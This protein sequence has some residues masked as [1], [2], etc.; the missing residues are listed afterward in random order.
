M[1]GVKTPFS[2]H[3]LTLRPGVVQAAAPGKVSVRVRTDLSRCRVNG[4]DRGSSLPRPATEK[5]GAVSAAPGHA[6]FYCWN[7]RPSTTGGR[8]DN[9]GAGRAP[10]PT[11]P[12]T[13]AGPFSNIPWCAAPSS[14]R[15]IRGDR[16]DDERATNRPGASRSRIVVSGTPRKCGAGAPSLLLRSQRPA[17][18]RPLVTGKDVGGMFD[19]PFWRRLDR[20]VDSIAWPWLMIAVIVMLI[21]QALR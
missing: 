19:T 20:F 13:P 3:R 18:D 7:E 2:L 15:R 16:R 12:T 17:N 4:P 11:S 21:V 6:T 1:R 5:H 10:L 14:D 9:S 8:S